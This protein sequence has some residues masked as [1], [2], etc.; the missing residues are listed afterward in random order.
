MKYNSTHKTTKKTMEWILLGLLAIHVPVCNTV[1]A[2]SCAVLIWCYRYPF[3]RCLPVQFPC[4]SLAF[5]AFSQPLYWT[6]VRILPRNERLPQYWGGIRL[7]FS[8]YATVHH[9]SDCQA[10]VIV[11]LISSQEITSS[12]VQ[13]FLCG[14]PP[15]T[16]ESLAAPTPAALAGRWRDD[17]T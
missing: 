14:K 8:P 6:W 2:R 16:I 4:P 7:L 10:V 17:F 9:R 3:F 12:I 15:L 11:A 5:L 13:F 1:V